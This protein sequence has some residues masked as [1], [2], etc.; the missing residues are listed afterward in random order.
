[1]ELYIAR[2]GRESDATMNYRLYE[3]GQHCQLR[4]SEKTELHWPHKLDR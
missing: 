3:D 2:A 1:M 4:K